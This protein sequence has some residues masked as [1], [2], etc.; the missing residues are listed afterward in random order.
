VRSR[1]VCSGFAPS[2]ESHY[3]RAVQEL[4]RFIGKLKKSDCEELLELADTASKIVAQR[5]ASAGTAH[6]RA[7]MLSMPSVVS[8]RT[9]AT[10]ILDRF[11]AHATIV[12]MAGKSYR[13]RTRAAAEP[14]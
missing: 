14:T 5:A 7:R 10:A 4:A 12:Q 8:I 13:L 9:A 3:R 6:C 11:L 1:S 2:S